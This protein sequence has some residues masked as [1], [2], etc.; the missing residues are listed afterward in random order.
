MN[1]HF[2][3]ETI[4]AVHA[5]DPFLLTTDIVCSSPWPLEMKNSSLHLVSFTRKSL[6]L[7]DL[8]SSASYIN[9]CQLLI[10]WLVAEQDLSLST[11]QLW[12]NQFNSHEILYH[13]C[14]FFF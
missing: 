4:E 1:F 5:D 11:Q 10:F 7:L 6:Y 8:E 3:F 13:S 9:F 14:Y 12:R 2:Q